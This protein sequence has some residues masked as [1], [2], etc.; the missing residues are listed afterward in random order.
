VPQ[1]DCK[2]I[3]VPLRRSGIAVASCI[4]AAILSASVLAE[5]PAGP[6][7]RFA[8][9]RPHDGKTVDFEAGYT[10]H[11][12]W[13]QKAGDKWSWYGWSVWAGDRQRWFIYATFGRTAE[14]LANPVAPLE[15]ERDNIVN[16]TPHCEFKGN[17][18]YQFLPSLSRG[19]GVPGAGS[20]AEFTY[21]ELKPGTGKAFE[22]A[23]NGTSTKVQGETL[24]Y[25]LVAGATSPRYLRI[26]SRA[27]LASIL[28]EQHEHALPAAA[29]SLI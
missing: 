15:D 25:R 14:E 19:N 3:S 10:R 2:G 13:H 6:Y 9:L 24:W 28:N 26:R 8:I 22:A 16:V 12:D 20:R 18:V 29:E 7:A 1:V 11:L 23:L 5:E 21:V 17:A 27:S 4:L